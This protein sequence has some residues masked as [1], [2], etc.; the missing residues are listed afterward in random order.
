MMQNPH[1]FSR[2]PASDFEFW[3]FPRLTMCGGILSRDA[4]QQLWAPA[5]RQPRD[6]EG[7]QQT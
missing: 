2:N 4:G 1:A 3:S 7:K 6:A 5:R